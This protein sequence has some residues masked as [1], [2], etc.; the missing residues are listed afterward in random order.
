MEL[1][2]FD[3]RTNSQS[4]QM[5]KLIIP[6]LPP[7][8]QRILAIYI[9]FVEFQNTLSSFR[10][11]KNRTHS[12]EQ[13][14]NEIRPYLPSDI[15][16]SIDSILNMISMMEMMKSMSDSNTSDPSEMLKSM[17]SPEQQSMFE[18]YNTMF[19]SNEGGNKNA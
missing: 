13:M 15:F 16:D 7:K 17:L 18:M 10:I 11:F 3:L 4:L 8:N 6:Y 2:P 14:L 9:K 5:V 12:T 1:T 19:S